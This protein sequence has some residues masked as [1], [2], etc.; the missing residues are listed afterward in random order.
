MVTDWGCLLERVFE[1]NMYAVTGEMKKMC[2][3]EL[4][5]CVYFL[6]SIFKMIEARSMKWGENVES[7]GNDTCLEYFL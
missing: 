2:N 6:C 5:I 4:K 1:L 3:Q 7:I